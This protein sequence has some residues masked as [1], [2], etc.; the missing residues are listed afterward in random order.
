[1]KL[2]SSSINYLYQLELESLLISFAASDSTSALSVIPGVNFYADREGIKERG[3]GERD[4][5]AGGGRLF[6]GDD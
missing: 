3:D 4:W 2:L 6:E 5:G 1:M